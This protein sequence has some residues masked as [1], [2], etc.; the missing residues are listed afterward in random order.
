MSGEQACAPE[1][2]AVK[3]DLGSLGQG[4][5][6]RRD[7]MRMAAALAL[8]LAAH[9]GIAL[10]LEPRQAP[11]AAAEEAIPVE[12][13]VEPPPPEPEPQPQPDPEEKPQPEAQPAPL[14]EKPVNDYA[15]ASDDDKADG[16]DTPTDQ[17]KEQ[18]QREQTQEEQQDARQEPQ[19]EQA[20]P[21]EEQQQAETPPAPIETPP[22]DQGD[23]PA[24]LPSMLRQ[25]MPAP[26]RM[27]QMFAAVPRLPEFQFKTPAPRSDDPKGTAEPNYLSKLYARI[28]KQMRAPRPPAGL[29]TSRGRVVFAVR[30][31]GRI[32][33]EAVQIRSGFA[34][35][36]A[37]ALAAVRKAAPYPPPPFGGPLYIRFDYGAL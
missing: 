6:A 29:A 34:E 25:P 32:F 9:A 2:Q 20:A 10:L 11:P 17:P 36:D 19:P 35:L 37:A 13:V 33:Q 7:R 12:I 23:T 28:M 16:K 24:P 15:R 3:L 4:V 21:P 1:V 14:D 27:S 26:N 18:E 8:C 30:S 5:A 22:Q 31:D